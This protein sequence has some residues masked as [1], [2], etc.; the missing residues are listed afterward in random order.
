MELRSYLDPVTGQPHLYE[1]GATEQEAAQV[2][3]GPGEDLP[4]ARGSR[5][6]LGRTASGRFLQV[7]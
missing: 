4:A 5:M 6:K 3:R 7:V 1:H 2:L